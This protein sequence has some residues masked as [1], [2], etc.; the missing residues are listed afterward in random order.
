MK[1]LDFIHNHRVI[2]IAAANQ[3]R[4]YFHDMRMSNTKLAQGMKRLS[5]FLLNKWSVLFEALLVKTQSNAKNS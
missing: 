4:D 5:I 3:M 1:S 2:L